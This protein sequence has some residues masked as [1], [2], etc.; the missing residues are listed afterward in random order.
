M[1]PSLAG[2]ATSSSG[3]HVASTLFA[4]L[5]VD[6]VCMNTHVAHDFFLCIANCLIFLCMPIIP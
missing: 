6:L 2:V 3:F 4:H 1:A 5:K